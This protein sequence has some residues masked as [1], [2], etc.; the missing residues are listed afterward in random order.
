MNWQNL[1][2]NQFH[3]F[4]RNAVDSVLQPMRSGVVGLDIGNGSVKL[5]ALQK[6]QDGWTASAAA[7]ATI[8]PAQDQT[9]KEENTVRAILD[10]FSRAGSAVSRHAVCS[11][12]GPQ[13][14]VRSF[15]FP[16]IPDEA[17]EQA[18]Q[19]EA[20]QVCALDLSHSTVDYQLVEDQ[21]QAKRT[22]RKGYLVI[23]LEE[24][25]N[26]KI[27]LAQQA[28]IKPI[29]LDVNSLAVLNCLCQLDQTL[30]NETFAVLDVGHT[31]SYLVILGP[32]GIPFVRDLTCSTQQIIAAIS[33]QSQKS[34]VQ[35]RKAL[36]E[37]HRCD[38]TLEAGLKNACGKL[39]ADVLD[40]LRF[41]SLQQNAEKVSQ[42][43]LS[44]GLALAKPFV[45]MMTQAL[46]AQ[47]KVFDLSEQLHCAPGQEIEKILKQY[48][49]TMTVAAGLA[50]RTGE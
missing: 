2:K 34:P 41:Y 48:G 31:Y 19:L 11:L 24:A 37:D 28:Q 23:G 32:D 40:T 26:Q 47:V 21:T 8:E 9:V 49:P 18:V 6:N 43:Y 10:C 15:C 1:I 45:H 16:P 14:A 36:A 17:L 12:S 46:P 20:Q 44:G 38:D 4:R 13:V 33:Q 30:A 50:M 25:M 29:L 22:H 27:G 5:V 3:N 35:V 7:C 39:I 42:V